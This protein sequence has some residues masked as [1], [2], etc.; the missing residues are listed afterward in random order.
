MRF[1][2]WRKRVPTVLLDMQ[3]W[4]AHGKPDYVTVEIP[5]I[6]EDECPSCGMIYYNCLCAH[7]S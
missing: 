3:Q 4:A 2:N 6:R 7:E 1:G 5:K